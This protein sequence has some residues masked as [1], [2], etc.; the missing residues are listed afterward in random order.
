ML[1]KDHPLAGSPSLTPAD[2]NGENLL[3]FPEIGF[4]GE[5]VRR[6]MPDS[7][8]LLQS[9]R[10]T[11]PELIDNS[12]LPCFAADLSLKYCGNALQDQAAVPITD[13]EVNITY[14]LACRAQDR[15]TCIPLFRQLERKR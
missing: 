15:R 5:L 2:L 13:P 14:C 9:E 7:R 8:F 11:F 6:K 12:V 4:W 10:C 3:L 1:P